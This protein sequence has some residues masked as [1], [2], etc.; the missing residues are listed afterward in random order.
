M[1]SVK[2]T[3]VR[4]EHTDYEGLPPGGKSM[5]GNQGKPRFL[6]GNRRDNRG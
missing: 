5:W 2:S 4:E 6:R 3:I 1:T